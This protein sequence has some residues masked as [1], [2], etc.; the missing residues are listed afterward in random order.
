MTIVVQ[1]AKPLHM[2]KKNIIRLTLLTV[3]IGGI[4]LVLSA[5]APKAVSGAKESMQECTKSGANEEKMSLDNL[6][7][8]FFS[9]L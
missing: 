3:A 5:S 7:H 1:S 8:Q 9:S 4:L 2:K 6:S